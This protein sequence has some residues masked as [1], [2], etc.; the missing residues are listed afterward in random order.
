MSALLR[1]GELTRLVSVQQ[2]A[3]TPD[4]YGQ[5]VSTWTEIKKVYAKIEALS[6]R[7]LVTA[8]S[9]SAEISH[10]FTLHYDAI[11]ASPKTAATYRFVYAGRM[12]NITATMNIDEDD[13][14][15]ELMAAEGL[16]DG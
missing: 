15:I 6:G 13:R 16:N 10:R 7:E 1:V 12:F 2:R 9:I 4:S 14:V 5:Q 11:F 3:T 8:Q